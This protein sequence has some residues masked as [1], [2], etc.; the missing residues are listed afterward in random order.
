MVLI[1]TVHILGV[2][3]KTRFSCPI[4]GCASV[5]AHYCSLARHIAGDK[6]CPAKHMDVIEDY[7]SA[8]PSGMIACRGGGCM[9]VA[10]SDREFASEFLP[11]LK[12]GD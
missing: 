11:S 9:D 7:K 2:H 4:D 3:L 8:S 10:Q 6:N 5:F 12:Y 1:F